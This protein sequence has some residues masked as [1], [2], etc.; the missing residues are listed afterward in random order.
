MNRR[1]TL[2]GCAAL[3]ANGALAPMRAFAQST[4]AAEARMIAKDATIYGYPL[5]D[6]YRIQ[7]S[8]FV[9]RGGAEF[10]A[11]WNTIFNNARV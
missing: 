5:V 2:L 9:D 8:Y 7:Y 11:P 1:Q 6:S 4:S 3:V 10:K